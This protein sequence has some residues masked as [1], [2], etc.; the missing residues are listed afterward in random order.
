MQHNF[1]STSKYLATPWLT[2]AT[3][4]GPLS[5]QIT[6]GTPD[7]GKIS[8][9]I[10]LMTIEAVSCLVKKAFIYSWKGIYKH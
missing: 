1:Q 4:V 8:S 9:S 7:L 10:F 3:K 2:L 6:L 5:D